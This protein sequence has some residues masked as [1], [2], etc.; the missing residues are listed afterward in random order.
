[1]AVLHFVLCERRHFSGRLAKER[2]SKRWVKNL[3][4]GRLPLF[5]GY[6][7]LW[8]YRLVKGGHVFIDSANWRCNMKAD[9]DFNNGTITLVC[10]KC[11]RKYV[12]QIDETKSGL[13]IKC[14]CNGVISWVGDLTWVRCY[15][16]PYG[17]TITPP[18]GSVS[19]R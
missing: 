14:Q 10:S 2:F 9:I 17:V 1:V 4:M 8:V 11:R 18:N 16:R 19:T 3:G 6:N 13:N 7:L 15:A 5:L 12:K